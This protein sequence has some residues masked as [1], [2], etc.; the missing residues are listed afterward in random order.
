MGQAC[1][2]IDLVSRLVTGDRFS[3]HLLLVEDWPVV[4]SGWCYLSRDERF[5]WESDLA[6]E[7]LADCCWPTVPQVFLSEDW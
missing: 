4:G 1:C 6:A 2:Q 5:G 3:W 7:K